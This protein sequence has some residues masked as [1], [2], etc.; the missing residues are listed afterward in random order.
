MS[1]KACLIIA[2]AIGSG[3]TA[4][5]VMG[6]ATTILP[7][8]LESVGTCIYGGSTAQT[9]EVTA[10]T[11]LVA[12]PFGGTTAYDFYSPPL[13]VAMNLTTGDK[14]GGTITMRNT[15]ASGDND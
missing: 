12:L 9:I 14:G 2:L 11:N 3:L 7:L 1:S 6:S 4:Q 10:G 5:N 15:S 13:T 8:G